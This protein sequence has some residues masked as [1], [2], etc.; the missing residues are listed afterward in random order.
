MI[1]GGLITLETVRV[2]MYRPELKP[3]EPEGT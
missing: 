3:G 2:I 1:G